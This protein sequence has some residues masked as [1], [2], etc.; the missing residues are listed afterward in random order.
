MDKLTKKIKIEVADAH[1]KVATIIDLAETIAELT[2]DLYDIHERLNDYIKPS[3]VNYPYIARIV[4]AIYAA[5]WQ[6][7][8]TNNTAIKAAEDTEKEINRARKDKEVFKRTGY[9]STRQ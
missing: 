9:I 2:E 5:A 3:N 7:E 8:G 1:D 4:S 6:I